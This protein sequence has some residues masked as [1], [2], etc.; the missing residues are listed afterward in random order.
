MGTQV[1]F[2]EIDSSKI[3]LAPVIEGQLVFTTNT[4]KLYRNI[5]G[6]RVVISNGGSR[7]VISSSPPTD[8]T[9]GDLWFI[10][11]EMV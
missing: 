2:L 10:E 3:N 1:K 9:V 5:N 4:H 7:S 8:L 11:E 6:E